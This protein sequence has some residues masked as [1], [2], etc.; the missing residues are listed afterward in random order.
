MNK[1]IRKMENN[2]LTH[3]KHE[4][5]HF[6]VLSD[7][8]QTV[9]VSFL[10]FAGKINVNLNL[11]IG[12]R[13][14]RSDVCTKM[15]EG[16]YSPVRLKQARL[17]SSLFMAHFLAANLE[18][19]GF[20]KQKNTRPRL[21]TVSTETILMAKSRPRRNQSQRSDLPQDRLAKFLNILVYFPSL[22]V[23]LQGIQILN[24]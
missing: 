8:R 4:T 19:A 23:L 16:Q 17:I 10:P 11:S 6:D 13:T 3:T 21:M 5:T 1:S 7:K 14:A 24:N 20:R 2:L 12:P 18:F 9:K 15:T 22:P